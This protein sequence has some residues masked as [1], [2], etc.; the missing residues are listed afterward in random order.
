MAVTKTIFMKL[1]CPGQLL[2]KTSYIEFYENSTKIFIPDTKTHKG[3]MTSTSV[4]FDS[5]KTPKNGEQKPYKST[6]KYIHK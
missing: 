2:A 1:K 6:Y 5:T 4:F 3:G